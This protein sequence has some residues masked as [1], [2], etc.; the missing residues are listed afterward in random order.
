MSSKCN[1]QCKN[2]EH[3][4]VKVSNP[5]YIDETMQRT[6][7]NQRYAGT[8]MQSEE[9][10]LFKQAISIFLYFLTTFKNLDYEET[11]ALFRKTNSITINVLNGHKQMKGA[12]EQQHFM[13]SQTR[14]TPECFLVSLNRQS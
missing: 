2:A 4:P 8:L 5:L 11:D 14:I 13:G 6:T 1:Y 9:I 3:W 10:T 7:R 12:F